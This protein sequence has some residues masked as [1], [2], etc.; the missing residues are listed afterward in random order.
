MYRINHGAVVVVTILHQI[1]RY[2]W[3]SPSVFFDPWLSAFRLN[4]LAL[5]DIS[6]LPFLLAILASLVFCYVFAWLINRLEISRVTAGVGLSTLLWLPHAGLWTISQY[7]IAKIPWSGILVDVLGT[8]VNA[9]L[10]GVVLTAW[11]KRV[12][13]QKPSQG[14][15]G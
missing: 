4:T 1:V 15:K 9:T 10:A 14:E 12:A 7:L 2:L 13:P 6:L 11:R 3:Y 5:T 8:L